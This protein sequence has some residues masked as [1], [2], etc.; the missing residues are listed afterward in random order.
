MAKRR[1]LIIFWVFLIV[2]AFFVVAVIGSYFYFEI[3]KLQLYG[4][5]PFSDWKSYTASIIKFIPGIGGMVKYKPLTVIPYQTLLESRI[6]AFQGVLN[7]QVASMDAKMVQLQNLENDLK[8]TQATIAASQS[9]LE[10]QEQQFNMQLLANQ[11]YR[12][13][14]QT[15]DQWISNSNPAQIGHVLATSN[16]SVNV[17]VDAM[18]NLSPQTAGSILQSISQVNPSLASSI[19]ETLTKVTK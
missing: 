18:I 19:I 15:L 12:S 16:I 13:R 17:L 6:N 11:N 8:V 9:N 7:T 5:T 10:I 1:G 4:I 14:I 2:L 3:N